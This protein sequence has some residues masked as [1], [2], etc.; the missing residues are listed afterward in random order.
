MYVET[1]GLN[2]MLTQLEQAGLLVSLRALAGLVLLIAVLPG[3]SYLLVSK[4]SFETRSKDLW[5]ARASAVFSAIGVF[6]IGF[7]GT[8]VLMISGRW[9]WSE[10]LRPMCNKLTCETSGIAIWAL[11]S[12][13]NLLVRSLLT[14]I[15]EQHHVG[16][17]YNTMAVL[18]TTGALVAGPLLSTTFRKGLDLGGA[19]IGLPFIGTGVLFTT[20][21]ILVCSVRLPRYSED[22]FTT[23]AS[24]GASRD[25]HDVEGGV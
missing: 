18:E 2:P 4:L 21:A 7:S 13:Y 19:W 5:L 16:T 14:S 12:G 22:G 3:A 10:R 6:C 20:A 25:G 24:A 8:P 1:H 17:L 15:V 9:I 11:G 23:S